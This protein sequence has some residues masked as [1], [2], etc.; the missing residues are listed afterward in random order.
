MLKRFLRSCSVFL[1]L[2]MFV[3]LINLASFGAIAEE[4]TISFQLSEEQMS[5]PEGKI[6]EEAIEDRT[7][8]S[9]N[10][11][12]SNGRYISAVYAQPVHYQAN[13][14]WEEIDN[15][16]RTNTDDTY[17]NTAGLWQVRFPQQ[18]S[19]NNAIAIT[20]DGYTLSFVMAGELR[21]PTNLIGDS[22]LQSTEQAEKVES[23]RING[24]TQVFA[25]QAAQ[26]SKG[27]IQID[28]LSRISEEARHKELVVSKNASA[29]LYADVYANTDVRYDLRANQVKES[30]ILESYNSSLQGYRYTLNVGDMIPVLQADNSIYF[31]DAKQ[32]NVIMVMPAPYLVDANDQYCDD[33]QV[34]LIGSGSTR[35]LIYLLPS[36]WLAAEER[37]WPVI[38]DPV[39]SAQIDALNIRDHTVAS[40]GSYSLYRT[41]LECGYG[42]SNH[43]HR[44]YLKYRDLPALP[45]SAIIVEATVQ[46]YKLNNTS[47]STGTMEAHLVLG[48]W[49]TNTLTWD[50]KPD[51]SLNVADYVVIGNSSGYVTWDVTDIARYWYE[52]E[53]YGM[54][55][56]MD[57]ATEDMG[58]SSWKHFYSSDYGVTAYMPSLTIE[59]QNET[60]L[61]AGQ[62]ADVNISTTEELK[63]F[64]FTPSSS[65]KYI[66]QSSNSTGDPR[67][68][69]YDSSYTYIGSDNDD[70]G[71]NNFRLEYNLAA[72]QTYHIAVGHTG[73]NTGT[74]CLTALKPATIENRFYKLSNAGSGKKLDVHGPNEEIYVHQWTDHT[75][76][77]QKW[78]IQKQESDGYY[79]IRSQYGHN[80]YV[81]V[82][83]TNTGEN[84]VRLY[85]TID[86]RTRWNLYVTS[87]GKF[88]LEPKNALGKALYAPDNF[89][90]TEMRLVWMGAGGN[91]EKWQLNAY[92]YS[93][94]TFSAFDMSDSNADEVA[95][96]KDYLEGYGYTDIGSYKNTE[97]FVSGQ[98]AKDIGRLSDIVYICGHGGRYSNLQIKDSNGTII[99]YI[100]PDESVIVYTQNE[101]TEQME[102]DN[103]NIVGIGAQFETGSI[104]TTDSYWN[105]GTKWVILENCNQLNYVGDLSYAHWDGLY[106]A[107]AWARTMLGDGERIHGFL[108][109][110]NGAPPEE[111]A[112]KV[113]ED[114]FE[115]AEDK[116]I[117]EAW[118][119]SHDDFWIWEVATNWAVMYHSANANDCLTSFTESTASGSPY[120]IYLE[121]YERDDASLVV[122]SDTS[123]T[124][125]VI[126]EGLYFQFAEVDVNKTSTIYRHLQN[127]LILDNAELKID[128]YNRIVYN[129]FNTH[130]GEANLGFALSDQQ[131]VS[132]A[133]QYL[134][135]LG[136]TPDGDYKASVSYARRYEIDVSNNP[137]SAPETIEYNVCFNRTVNGIDLLSDQ[138]DGIVVSF[139]KYGITKLQYKWRD[140]QTVTAAKNVQSGVVTSEQAE[141]IYL[142]VLKEASQEASVAASIE[143]TQ[144]PVVTLAYMEIDGQI[145][146]VWACSPNGAYGNHIF[147]DAQTGQQLVIE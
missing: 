116:T 64:R 68:L 5:I 131:A 125:L 78:L 31:Y 15:T 72:Y 23:L 74:F 21:L 29:L 17:S 26:T 113:L 145:K 122:C 136:L 32:E 126:D 69:L 130:T 138:G 2:A 139:D 9:K 54:M 45:A 10:F 80:K 79:T 42:P 77:Q 20:K 22:K 48:D 140:V 3:N 96:V 81:G 147:I 132:T 87:D 35:T 108:G 18:I 109:Y 39:V 49:E 53:N 83:N 75:D 94:L 65:G 6:V 129:N 33:V 133:L 70:A 62:S 34:L 76:E 63:Y 66:F 60:T 16:L 11:K 27:Q 19:D 52:R 30:I 120:T 107:Q 50:N 137:V 117:V 142:A 141:N 104:T 102:I 115:C 13:G 124:N 97:G 40:N 121:R 99:E 112:K 73:T 106:P 61:S 111:K 37:S 86:D 4:A 46:M 128:E 28:D 95:I 59:Y 89:D 110:Y 24:N 14:G 93:G 88:I 44:V 92:S 119:Q 98:L 100:C 146:T 38:L 114:F 51:Y 144:A 25:V 36:A 58:G 12:L 91:Y 71:N 135:T 7:E 118:K 8:F 105:A 127:A 1:I 67:I 57:E 41:V 143:V 123:A 84:N 103:K 90:G 55:F 82:E 43:I 134:N 56:K 101:Q 85:N 47:N